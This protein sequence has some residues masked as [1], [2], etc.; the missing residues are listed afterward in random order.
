MLRDFKRECLAICLGNRERI[1]E[2][3]YT[4]LKVDVN[5]RTDNLGNCS[6]H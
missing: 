5:D 6:P 3:W 1:E 4:V 2:R